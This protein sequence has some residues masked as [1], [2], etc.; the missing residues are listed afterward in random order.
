MSNNGTGPAAP[1]GIG[2]PAPRVTRTPPQGVA[3]AAAYALV[4]VCTLIL[5][6]LAYRV[7]FLDHVPLNFAS[8][9]KGDNIIG[10]VAKVALTAPPLFGVLRLIDNQWGGLLISHRALQ[11]TADATAKAEQVQLQVNGVMDV[12]IANAVTAALKA[13]TVSGGDLSGAYN[14][15]ARVSKVTS[16]AAMGA[17]TSAGAPAAARAAV[18]GAGYVGS[19]DSAAGAAGAVSAGGVAATTRGIAPRGGG[20]IG[21]SRAGWE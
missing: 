6:G 12:R 21:P 15:A 9:W 19:L 18:E 3:T 7:L 16:L 11:A 5:L 17:A 13:Y 8:V 4:V 20:G 14:A 1:S 10:F 2:S